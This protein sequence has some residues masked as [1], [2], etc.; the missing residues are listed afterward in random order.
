MA[1]NWV[2]LFL[3]LWLIVSPWLLGFSSISLMKWSD[4]LSGLFLVI[5]NAWVIFGEK[6][7]TSLPSE[8]QKVE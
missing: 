8:E 1:V 6:R 4:I 3:G 5:I 7:A 2:S